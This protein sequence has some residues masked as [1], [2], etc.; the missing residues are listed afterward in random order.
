MMGDLLALLAT[1]LLVGANAFFVAAEFSL[2]SARRDRLE[3]LAEQ[4]RASAVTA[5][6]AREQP[7]PVVARPQLGTTIASLMLGGLGE[8]AV[9]DLLQ[10][11]FDLIGVSPA[12]VHTVSFVMALAIV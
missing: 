1:M 7:P 10:R 5:L 12:V 6:R 4:G 3:A 8:P 9:A 11:P 2:I